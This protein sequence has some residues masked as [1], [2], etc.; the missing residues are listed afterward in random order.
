MYL[1][2]VK[3]FQHF[4]KLVGNL[5]TGTGF[6]LTLVALV[7][8]VV[9]AQLG[10]HI[11]KIAVGITE[12][13]SHFKGRSIFDLHAVGVKGFVGDKGKA[14]IAAPRFISRYSSMSTLRIMDRA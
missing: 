7:A 2:I 10:G 5:L 1:V 4:H 8:A 3:I 9:K 6:V 12:D 13:K 14:N 11:I